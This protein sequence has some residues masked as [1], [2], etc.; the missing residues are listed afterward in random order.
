MTD[1][2]EDDYRR[3]IGEAGKTSFLPGTGIEIIHS[4]DLTIAPE[5]VL[6]DFD[7][8][9][10]LVREGWPEVMVPMMVE[11]LTDTGTDESAET[12]SSVAYEFIMQLNGKQTIYQMM[13][14]AEEVKKRGGVPR[15]PS[16]YKAEYHDLLMQR[17][18]GRREGL[19]NGE[20]KREELIVPGSLEILGALRDKGAHLYLA[21]GTDEQFVKEETQLLGM[22]EY[23]GENIYGALQDYRS[24]SKARVIE[25]ILAENEVGG[26]GL[27]GLG[28]GYVEIQNVKRVGGTA[29][30]VASD[31]AGR[32]G[33]PDAWKRDRLIGVGADIVVP[34]FSDYKELIAYL[35][36]T[37]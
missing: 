17:I 16:E 22:D 25:R 33:K 30:G 14:L 2:L 3:V 4:V 1:Y 24:F 21:S 31:E 8:T 9:L 35:W 26:A 28:D 34:D 6:F 37:E 13:R 10:S 19:R 29:I 15:E 20:I 27:L 32:S 7:G 5:H 11:A 23:F 18:Q 12:L 36:G